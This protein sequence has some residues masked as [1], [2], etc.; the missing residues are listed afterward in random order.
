MD[1]N[2]ITFILL[3][4][5]AIFTLFLIVTSITSQY[6]TV[7][8]ADESQTE[9]G[10][11][12]P[13]IVFADDF[14]REDR[15]RVTK[16]VLD[17]WVYYKQSL[18]DEFEKVAVTKVGTTSPL[19]KFSAYRLGDDEAPSEQFAL[20]PDKATR[21]YESWHPNCV[22]LDCRDLPDDFKLQYPRLVEAAKTTN[23]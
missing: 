9:E 6:D 11:F 21:T 23:K 22:Y 17:P 4:L 8:G 15:E 3:A 10:T 19:Y 7:T 20:T 5:G 1:K 13:D 2:K 18:D 12:E 14:T 16:L